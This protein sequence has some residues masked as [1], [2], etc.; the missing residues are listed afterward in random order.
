MNGLSN[1]SYN[2]TNQ[3]KALMTKL[4]S[5]ILFLVTNS[6]IGFCQNKKDTGI[7]RQT[8]DYSNIKHNSFY[9]SNNRPIEYVKEG[10]SLRI[11]S[12][13]LSNYFS[14][15]Q[16]ANSLFIDNKFMQASTFFEAA[17]SGNNNLGKVKDRYTLACCYAR[18]NKLDSAFAQL[19]I[20]S[21]S[22]QF[23]DLQKISS[24]KHFESLK[25]DKRWDELIQK[26][27]QNIEKFN[28]PVDGKRIDE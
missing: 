19:F 5:L 12:G 6:L 18:I 24:E 8:D 3:N 21:K 15:T 16:R 13:S 27:K 7:V 1:G 25:T 14:L 22:T 23:F 20:I 11:V 17:I 4:V 28:A 9:Y 2:I 10:D 26:I